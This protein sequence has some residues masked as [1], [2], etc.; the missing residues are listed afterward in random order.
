[1]AVE[2]K[3]TRT[4]CP[5]CLY[6]CELNINTVN[7]GDFLLRKIEYN[8]ASEINQ[9]RLCARGNLANI[10]LEHRNRLAYPLYNNQ[11]NDWVVALSQIK[12]Q[13]KENP[14]EQIAITYDINNTLEEINEIFSFAQDFKI[15]WL[16]RSYLEPESFFNYCTGDIKYANLKDIEQTNGLLII[17]DIFN[18]SPVI[19]KLIL[20]VKYADRNHRL[21]YID[22]VKTKL[23]GF[24][25]KFLWIKPG[26]E[27]LAMLGLIASL[28]KNAKDILGEKNYNLINKELPTI[29]KLCGIAEG[30][31]TEIATTFASLPKGVIIVSMDYG[32]TD[33]PLLFSLLSQLLTMIFPNDKKFLSL[34]LSS[35]PFGKTRFGEIFE[36]IK[37]RRIKILIN[38]GEFF[39]FYYPQLM[40]DL[41]NLDL[42]VTT[43]TFRQKLPITGWILPMA[44]IL[45][46]SGTINTLW[47]KQPINPLAQPVNG[48]KT[49]TEIIND[50]AF[51]TE[52]KSKPKLNYKSNISLDEL[53]NRA[54][55]F[56]EQKQQV[57][58]L[59]QIIGEETAFGYRGILEEN[60]HQIVL[61]SFSANNLQVHDGDV[62]KLTANSAESNFTVK[63]K[64]NIHNNVAL[65]SVNNPINRVF[66][67]F[68]ID[69]LTNDIIMPTSSGIINK[70]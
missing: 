38:F 55:A 56:I 63:I 17:G 42:F 51:E 41:K 21:F 68:K 34:S 13:L 26:T 37:Q 58:D 27:P 15:N 53:I 32:K 67:P 2:T 65:I 22:S 1:M 50:I 59:W 10:I 64:D 62:V 25:N 61:N 23:A 8:P 6:G 28:G 60:D 43:A 9:G 14:P 40:P 20:D 31:F 54:L 24:A 3:L 7:R 5:F 4:T 39:P 29:A 47:T 69:N 12:R 52:S 18:K 33:D 36:Q 44:S 45:E 57:N 16:A 19:A 35:L 46:K 66:F 48:S 30:V 11:N 49:T 70:V